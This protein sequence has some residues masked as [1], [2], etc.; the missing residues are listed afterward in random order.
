MTQF[1]QSFSW[2][3]NWGQLYLDMR[4]LSVIWESCKILDQSSTSIA[5]TGQIS[6]NISIHSFFTTSTSASTWTRLLPW[7]WK[8]YILLTYL[9]IQALHGKE[10]QKKTT[11]RSTTA[12][13]SSGPT[14]FHNISTIPCL[15]NPLGLDEIDS[16]K[17][18]I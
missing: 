4:N 15:F 17:Q 12:I 7:R 13:K 10:T 8:Q 11:N 5:Q 14:K 6:S 3:Y 2:C 1:I 16:S 18:R 9:N